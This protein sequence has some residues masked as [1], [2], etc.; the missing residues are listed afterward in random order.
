MVIRPVPGTQG[1]IIRLVTAG[2]ETQSTSE[3]TITPSPEYFAAIKDVSAHTLAPGGWFSF[4]LELSPNGAGLAR[5][6]PGGEEVKKG[7]MV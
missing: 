4:D 6:T 3:L 1:G 7:S 5:P 2:G